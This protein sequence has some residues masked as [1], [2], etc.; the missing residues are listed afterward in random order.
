[1]IADKQAP[2]EDRSYALYRAINCFASSG[3]NHCGSED[4]AKAERK[5]WFRTLKGTYGKT[6]WAAKQKYYW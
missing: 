1:M 6:R 4:I 3:Y 2:A 5:A